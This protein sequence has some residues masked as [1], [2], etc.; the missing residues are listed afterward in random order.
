MN[1]IFF[2]TSEFAV[3]ALEA[4]VTAGLKP[5]V[6]VTLPDQPRGRG[7]AVLPSPIK[8]TAGKYSIPLWQPEKLTDAK[9][10]K[11]F[12]E[13]EWNL[14]VVVAYGKLIPQNLIDTPKKG[15]LNIH[16]SLLPELRG[17]SP[18]QY[19]ILEG[20]QK[21]GVTIMLLD[22]GMDHGPIIAQKEMLIEPNDTTKTLGVRLA[23]LGSELLITAIPAWLEGAL[24][25]RTQ[26]HAK[27][28]FSKIIE[29]NRGRLD[30]A[31]P[32]ALV[33]QTV[34]AFYPWPGTFSFWQQHQRGVS[35]RLKIIEVTPENNPGV[36]T[37]GLVEALEDDMIVWCQDGFLRITKIQAEGKK[38]L[39]GK[40]FLHGHRD[41]LGTILE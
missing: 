15:F 26:D 33:T 24:Q 28:T 1:L 37:P 23:K 39:S 22:T 9:F 20:K 3:P 8:V 5:A 31:K 14:G 25:S 36:K 41:I 40:E 6:V 32:T 17:P 13:T 35:T 18:I 16:P 11:K 7:L 10:L 29:K 2:G 12:S 19:A 30:W 4:L 21:T 34:R 38:V 27:A